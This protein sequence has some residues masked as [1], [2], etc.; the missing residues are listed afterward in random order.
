MVIL[1]LLLIVN[2]AQKQNY[3]IG[4]RSL[5]GRHPVCL[6]C[7]RKM[8]ISI[9]A[10]AIEFLQ[11]V[12][13][14]P[15]TFISGWHSSIER[16]ALRMRTLEMP[17]NIIYFLAQGIDHFKIPAYLQAD[18]ENQKLLVVSLWKTEKGTDRY[19]A[20][21]RND[22]LLKSFNQFLFL[23]ISPNGKLVKLY[24]QAIDQQKDVFIFDHFSNSQWITKDVIPVSK[25][26]SEVLL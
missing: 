14:H 1:Q 15:I 24:Q 16:K 22:Y 25:Y 7:S 4:N 17:S 8:P 2:M 9:I 11:S 26:N 23:Y 20:K 18:Y 21:I 13:H 5:L 12:M 19:K 6:F 3:Y 10:P